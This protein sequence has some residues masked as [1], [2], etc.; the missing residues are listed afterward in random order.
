MVQPKKY[1]TEEERIAARESGRRSTAK[2]RSRAKEAATIPDEMTDR[3]IFRSI[4]NFAD[5]KA[6]ASTQDSGVA[7]DFPPTTTIYWVPCGLE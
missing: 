4:I 7:A 3:M 6:Q 2:H 1:A 5:G